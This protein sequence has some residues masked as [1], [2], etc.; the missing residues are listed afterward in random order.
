M[1]GDGVDACNDGR[2]AVATGVPAEDIIIREDLPSCAFQE[3]DGGEEL[4]IELLPVGG[5]EELRGVLVSG[6]DPL[7]EERFDAEEPTVGEGRKAFLFLTF[8][9]CG[10]GKGNGKQ[11]E[12]FSN[13]TLQTIK[14]LIFDESQKCG[15]LRRRK[16]A[17]V[18]Y[19]RRA[20]GGDSALTRDL[21]R[22]K[23]AREY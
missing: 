15:H 5:D 18:R 20:T 3:S 4:P 12:T 10:G 17:A 9:R 6:A 11:D 22:R 1:V 23:K 8:D 7:K 21:W 16:E 14:P 19:S 2:E 13:P